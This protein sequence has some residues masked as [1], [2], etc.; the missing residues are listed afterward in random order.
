MHFVKAPGFLDWEDEY[1]RSVVFNTFVWMQI[2]NEFNN[3]R[4]DNKFNIFTG[5]HRNWF[6]IGINIMMIGCQ[7]VI[8]N[9]GGAAFSI[10]RINGVQWAVCV[11]VASLSLPWAICIRMF[12]DPWFAAIARVVGKP[13]VLAYHPLSQ[14]M[15]RLGRPLG[16]AV[17][18]AAQ[19]IRKT[20][21]E[22]TLAES[23][24]SDEEK[25]A[26]K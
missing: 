13:F 8:T 25:G 5:L 11:V 19:K 18:R 23:D 16:R 1:R 12:P 21:K 20:S 26:S 17:H 9:F 22:A 14:A 24:A 6:F 10:V 15:H 7:A 3:R 4:L 2:F